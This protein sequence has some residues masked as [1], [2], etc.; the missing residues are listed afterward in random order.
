MEQTII[1]KMP[2]IIRFLSDNRQVIMPILLVLCII[3]IVPIVQG[4]AADIKA[5]KHLRWR[6]H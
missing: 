2:W 4:I 5:G 6:H 3:A 1:Q